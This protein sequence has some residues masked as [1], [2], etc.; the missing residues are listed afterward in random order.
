MMHGEEVFS[1]RLPEVSPRSSAG[2]VVAKVILRV[3]FSSTNQKSH[4]CQVSLH[5]TGA[6]K[7]YSAQHR[8]RVNCIS[9]IWRRRKLK[10]SFRCLHWS[11][12]CGY[13]VAQLVQRVKFS[14]T[15]QKTY[16]I[17]TFVH[18]RALFLM[19]HNLNFSMD[20]SCHGTQQ[21]EIQPRV[22]GQER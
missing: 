22:L 8:S 13:A 19:S 1:R 6:S 18:Q 16:P 14:S 3:K 9:N 17:Q 20:S 7:T 15:N 10:I 5:T 11:E 21:E 2:G 12:W 4:P